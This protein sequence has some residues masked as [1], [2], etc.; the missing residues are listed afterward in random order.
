MSSLLKMAL[1][2][3]LVDR[4][5]GPVKQADK[6]LD[7]MGKTAGLVSNK[8]GLLGKNMDLFVGRMEKVRH[9]GRN[10]AITGVAAGGLLGLGAVP[11]DAARAEHALRAMGNVGEMTD[12]QLA[13]MNSSLLNTTTT[14]N[15]MQLELIAGMNT[16]VAAGLNPE[17][18]TRFMPTIGKAATATQATVD[19]LSKTLFAVYDNLKVPEKHLV[20]SIDT[21]AQSG[22]EGRFELNNMARYFPM[23]T[24]G[25]QS[26]GMKGVP[27]VAALGAALQIAM[28][29]AGTPEEAA[30]NFE[31]FLMK[32]TSKDT[33]KNF[34][35]LGVDVEQEMKRATAKGLDPIE[36]ML[37]VIMKVTGGNKFKLGQIFGDMQVTN[38]IVPMMKNLDE[39][40][41]IRNKTMTAS[42]VVDKDYERMMTTTIE[43]WKLMKVTLAKVVMPNLA[44]PMSLVNGLLKTMTG[45][46]FL[47]KLTFY[48]IAATV[49]GGG[50]LFGLG[51]LGTLLPKVTAGW[52]MLTVAQGLFKTTQ[53]VGMFGEIITTAGPASIWL[54]KMATAIKGTAIAQWA[55]NSALLANP[56]AWAVVAVLSLAA[57]GY[58]VYKHWRILKATFFDAVD[59]V[60][61]GG[62]IVSSLVQGIKSQAMKPVEAIKGIVQ[63]IRNHL[64]FSP[65]KEG[66]LR[67]IHRIRLIETIAGTMKPQPMVTAMRAATAATMLAITPVAALARPMSTPRADGGA[68]ITFSPQ[69][70]IQGGG[71]SEQIRGAVNQALSLSFSE[72]EGFMK[73]YEA[74]KS[75]TAF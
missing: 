6:T 36:H 21:L 48:G 49:A 60:R 68:Q 53:K 70:T 50:L 45:N 33:V 58:Q 47:T 57:A 64:P 19:D 20:Q 66:P 32:I 69:I 1:V 23:L 22:K 26:L 55:L 46:A 73:R 11:G 41:R 17:I 13:G 7:G 44:G 62:N 16:L 54:G 40:R 9:A 63:K 4:M 12:R 52:R 71:N 51:A 42:G 56:I 61:A 59:W 30:R 10:I 39:Y 24:A 38:F 74:Q 28:K 75:R 5:S 27:A 65:A 43:Q 25:A 14:V 31:N 35:K 67:D 3:S 72:F 34:K 29:G 8:F 15:Q 37:N 2:L 18:A